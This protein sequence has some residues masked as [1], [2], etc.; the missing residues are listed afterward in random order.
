MLT[1]DP[2]IYLDPDTSRSYTYSQVRS[3]AI[4]FGTGL[5][6]LWN[7]KKNDVLTLF[8][9]NSIDTPSIT[10]G[11][12]W[13]GGILAPANPAYT[14]DELAFQLKDA[15]VRAI[16]TQ[17]PN[18]PVARAAAAKVGIPE[19]RI[20]LMGDD[21]DPKH[22]FKHFSSIR[23]TAGTSRYRRIKADPK[24]DLAF[25]VY[26]SGTTGHPKG[27]MLSHRNIVANILQLKAGE[28]E[29]LTWNGG[30][31]GEGDKTLAFLPFFHIYGRFGLTLLP[32]IVYQECLAE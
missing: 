30:E 8:T 20:I 31:E 27:V 32:F 13:A 22:K 25:L 24:K 16:V 11:C 9:P 6:A 28:G 26:S 2:V 23:N 21:R 29:N 1:Y 10:W 5:R 14:A 7:W 18:L 17:V 15:G 4:E 19:N 3:T 12:H